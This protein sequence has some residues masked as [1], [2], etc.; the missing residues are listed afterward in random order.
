MS[1]TMSM[2]L[3]ILLAALLAGL[4]WVV[5]RDDSEAPVPPA[6]PEEEP[7][8]GENVRAP[9]PFASSGPA[10]DRER[11]VVPPRSRYPARRAPNEDWDPLSAPPQAG[12]PRGAVRSAPGIGGRVSPDDDDDEEDEDDPE[13][14]DQATGGRGGAFGSRF[15]R[16]V[17]LEQ[18]G[19]GEETEDAVTLGLEWLRVHQDPAGH[20]DCDG[21][22][23]MDKPPDL[24]DGAGNPAYDPGVTGLALL[25]F[26]GHAESHKYG[27]YRKT[28]REGLKYLK[29][30][31]DPEG[32]FGPRT[33]KRFLY[34]HAI[35][36]LALVEAYG[37]T[38]S[39]LFKASA[40]QGVD[41]I[42]KCRNPGFV[43][44]YGVRPKENDTSL[45]G[46]MILALKMAKATGLRVD[47]NA[48]RDMKSWV[49]RVTEPETGRAGYTQMFNTAAWEHEPLAWNPG[50]RSEALTAL[51]ILARVFT[52][53]NPNRS[54]LIGKGTA[55]CLGAL[56]KWDT[57]AG[58]IDMVYW[59]W[60]SLAM[61]QVGRE[62]F[63]AWN[64]ALKEAV[65]AGQRTDAQFNGSWDP[66]GPWGKQG[67]R[68][69][70]TAMMVLTLESYYRYAKLFGGR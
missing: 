41:F 37:L 29:Q 7:P 54:G 1:R 55:L 59:Y 19:G 46:W 21:F 36:T 3:P 50:D 10:P 48:F 42:A 68:V 6:R 44:R 2:L 14:A 24:T 69:Y 16:S 65:L 52:G 4:I 9:D 25:A 32:C 61:F 18:F 40:Q 13:P 15:R 70:S 39:P 5:V 57:G 67:G 56:P 66:V 43:W 51:G 58:T 45:S 8:P 38:S 53:E 26:L 47:M 60:A 12:P 31:Q 22:T 20:W 34:N 64:E 30:I 63:L 27:R 17:L 35:A 33:S 49:A 62:P 23:K 11:P 28:V